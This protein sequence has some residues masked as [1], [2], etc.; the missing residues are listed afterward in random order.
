VRTPLLG[1]DYLVFNTR[2]GLFMDRQNPRA[3]SHALD[4]PA[5]AAAFQD[6]VT[7]QALPPRIPGFRD[8]ELYPLNRPGLRLA[9]S[10]AR[11][12]GGRAT[13]FV[14]SE[15]PC[16]QIGRIVRR[17]LARI[18]IAVSV[19]QVADP[20]KVPA[21]DIALARTGA[22]HPGSGRLPRQ[23][24]RAG[25]RVARTASRPDSCTRRDDPR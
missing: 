3:A 7:D 25:R 22:P 14:C 2:R 11:G 6:L 12:R 21:A 4:R 23:S 18:G 19:K 17:N 10:L 9:K 16:A 8:V 20:L 13:L 5:L 15:P 24:R 1:T